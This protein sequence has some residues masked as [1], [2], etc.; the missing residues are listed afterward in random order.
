[1]WLQ[2]RGHSTSCPTPLAGPPRA[3]W[4][5]WAMSDHPTKPS[6]G[7]RPLLNCVTVVNPLLW[8][9]LC[10]FITTMKSECKISQDREGE[11]WTL[12]SSMGQVLGWLWET[13]WQAQVARVLHPEAYKTLGLNS[14]NLCYLVNKRWTIRILHQK[15]PG[16]WNYVLS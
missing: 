16:R 3:Y 14:L 2:V 10:V 5:H 8:L 15:G 7:G 1:M 12:L 13:I 6:Q 11:V 9:S 4:I